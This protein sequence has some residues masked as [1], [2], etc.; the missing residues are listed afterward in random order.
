M[1][2]AASTQDLSTGRAPRP[3]YQDLFREP[4]YADGGPYD[5]DQDDDADG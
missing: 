2:T 5:C 3:E 1:T 4:V